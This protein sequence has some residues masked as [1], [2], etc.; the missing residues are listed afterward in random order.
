ME[1]DYG[2]LTMEITPCMEKVFMQELNLE[3]EMLQGI[4]TELP[5]GMIKYE[6][7]IY[8]DL[9]NDIIKEFCLRVIAKDL[10]KGESK[11]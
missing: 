9:K 6:V 10:H 11:Q 2:E 4:R 7:K 1:Q 5:N 8:D 3:I